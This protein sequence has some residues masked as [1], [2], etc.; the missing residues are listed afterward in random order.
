MKVHKLTI[1]RKDGRDDLIM[2]AQDAE[3]LIDGR[4]Y[5]GL[6]SLRLTVDP[7]QADVATIELLLSD[8]E[9]EGHVLVEERENA[10]N[11]GS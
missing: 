11:T 9:V 10:S 6:K 7:T 3:I 4:E 1:R 8:V 5:P 2:L